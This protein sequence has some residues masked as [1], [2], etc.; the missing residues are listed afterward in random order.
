MIIDSYLPLAVAVP[1]LLLELIVVV[2]IYG[3][4]ADSS[5]TPKFFSFNS[6]YS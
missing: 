2:Y 6:G 1:A 4:S 5:L 3:E